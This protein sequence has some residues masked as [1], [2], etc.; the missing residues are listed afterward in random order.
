MATFWE[1][2]AHS[3][4]HMFSLNFDYFLILVMSRFGFEGRIWDLI[5]PVPGAGCSKHC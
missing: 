2:A 5:A 4:D 3:I 1:R